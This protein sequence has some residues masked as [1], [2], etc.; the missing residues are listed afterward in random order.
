MRLLDDRDAFFLHFMTRI[1]L[2]WFSGVVVL[3]YSHFLLRGADKSVLLC[4]ACGVEGEALPLFSILA[5][6]RLH[7]AR[8]LLKLRGWLVQPESPH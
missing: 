4:C 7:D 6:S 8:A 3:S 1:F 5:G 2:L